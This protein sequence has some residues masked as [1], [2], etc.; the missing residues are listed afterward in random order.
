MM[1]QMTGLELA[2]ALRASGIDLPVLYMSG[3]TEEKVDVNGVLRAGDNFV[4][5]PLTPEALLRAVYDALQNWKSQRPVLGE[6][7]ARRL[8][9]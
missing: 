7:E 8:P 5:K 2:E 4:A 6:G 1:P 9:V 3:Y